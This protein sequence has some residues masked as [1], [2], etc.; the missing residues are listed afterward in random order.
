MIF[1]NLIL[2]VF[3]FIKELNFGIAQELILREKINFN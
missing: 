2:I 1:F 3:I